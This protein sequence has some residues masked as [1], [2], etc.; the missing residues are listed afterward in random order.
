MRVLVASET[1]YPHGGGAEL[2]TWL[3]AKML[4]KRGIK[5]NVLT[6]QQSAEPPIARL[7]ANFLIHRI[8][9]PIKLIGRYETLL[10]AGFL[11]TPSTLKL[12]REC[13]LLYVPGNWLTAMLLAKM[14]EKPVLLHSHNYALACPLS[15]MYDP[16]T[17]RI[18]PS[19]LRGF[20]LHEKLKRGPLRAFVSTMLQASLGRPYLRL[21]DL[22]DVIIL[23]SKAQ[24]DLLAKVRFDLR[25]K[26]HVVP[27]PCP[28]DIELSPLGSGVAYFGG[29]AM[30]KGYETIC[31]AAMSLESN[32]ATAEPI[33]FFL[34]GEGLG[35]GL[36]RQGAVE[37]HLMGHLEKTEARRLLS[38]VSVVAFTSLSPE[39]SSY[40]V[41]EAILSGR[42]LIAS[43]VGGVQEI[44][45]NMEPGI[46]L[47]EPGDVE[48]LARAL[49][50]ALISEGDE[51]HLENNRD[52]LLERTAGTENAEML[53]EVLDA[54]VH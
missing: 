15:L 34:A 46:W 13:D 9:L 30:A 33:R 54:L 21:A 7:N 24:Y 32:R 6:R 18:G 27:N 22:A 37:M 2:A 19:S 11:L 5:I 40:V 49:S 39:P 17:R 38:R 16:Y 41:Q 50:E 8:P 1:F 25:P 29:I 26:L 3:Y 4:S 47:V 28:R 35:L 45:S 42:K 51:A 53:I 48:G 14:C 52:K 23:V 44:V 20:Y 43:N 36:H 12:F 31:K 10:N